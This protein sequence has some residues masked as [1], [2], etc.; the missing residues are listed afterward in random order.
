M[1]ES[2]K[3]G[4][5]EETLGGKM[6]IFKTK[7]SGGCEKRGELISFKINISGTEMFILS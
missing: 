4:R 2:K 7:R 3:K 5:M 1:L 6:E